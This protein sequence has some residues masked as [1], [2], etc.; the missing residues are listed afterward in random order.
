MEFPIWLLLTPVVTCM[1]DYRRGLDW[2]MDLLTTY[3]HHSELQV[4]T[5]PLVI[6]IHRTPQHLLSLFP[7]CCVF[8]SRSL[9]TDSNIGDSATSSAHIVT[10]RRISRNWTLVICQLNYSAISSQPSLQSST[11]LPTLSWQLNSLTHQPATSLHSTE[12]H[13]ASLGSSLYIL[14]ADP[15]ENAAP[16]NPSVAVAQMLLTCLLAVTKQCMF[17]LVII[18]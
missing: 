7:A 16:K 4:I 5:A 2:W 1:C 14:G 3:I 8:N 11:Q 12:L 10:L 9:A 13:S 6:T 18:A 17:L 15:T